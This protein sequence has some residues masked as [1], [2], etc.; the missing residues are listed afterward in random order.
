M[1]DSEEVLSIWFNASKSVEPPEKGLC[2]LQHTPSN[3]THRSGWKFWC[4]KK[5]R[6]RNSQ[7]Y[8]E[9]LGCVS[10]EVRSGEEPAEALDRYNGSSCHPMWCEEASGSKPPPEPKGSPPHEVEALAVMVPLMLFPMMDPWADQDDEEARLGGEEEE[11]EQH[12]HEDQ[13]LLM[14]PEP[15]LEEELIGPII[16]EDDDE[17]AVVPAAKDDPFKANEDTNRRYGGDRF[18]ESSMGSQESHPGAGIRSRSRGG[19]RVNGQEFKAIS[20]M[21]Q[22]LTN[23]TEL[24]REMLGFQREMFASQASSSSQGEVCDIALFEVH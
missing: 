20:T 10:E 23:Q 12:F 13:E 4:S 2:E 15:A 7:I 1:G 22:T 8:F 11:A 17:Q 14:D 9:D 18:R 6:Y 3:P 24:Q 16:H 19:Q 21:A 5:G